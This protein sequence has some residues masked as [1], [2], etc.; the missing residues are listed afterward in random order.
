MSQSQ[1]SSPLIIKAINAFSDNYIWTITTKNSK[2]LTLV[3]PG[4]AEVCIKF[5]EKQFMRQI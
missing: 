2:S 5:I 1:T 4:D 3:D